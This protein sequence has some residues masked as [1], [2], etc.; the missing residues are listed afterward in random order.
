M[1]LPLLDNDFIA[2]LPAVSRSGLTFMNGGYKLI[3]HLYRGAWSDVY[4]AS[5]MESIDEVCVKSVDLTRTRSRCILMRELMFHLDSRQAPPTIVTIKDWFIDFRFPGSICLVM[6]RCSFTLSHFISGA[7]QTETQRVDSNEILMFLSDMIRS[8][9]FLEA[10]GIIHRDIHSENILW[11]SKGR[12][13]WRLTDFGSCHRIDD[14]NGRSS[15]VGNLLYSSPEL[16]RGKKISTKTDVWSLGCCIFECVNLVRPFTASKILNYRNS[17]EFS[18]SFPAITRS[19]LVRRSRGSKFFIWLSS[20]VLEQL[21]VVDST[22][23]SEAS[24]IL[25]PDFKDMASDGM[26]A[27]ELYSNL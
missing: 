5:V 16:I 22:E 8:I 1:L 17:P 4:T 13:V 21:L 10:N 6:D 2:S 19:C 18:A 14:P 24:K 20:L 11:S 23:R 26:S 7:N 3:G 27:H 25:I 15:E 12:G 9:T